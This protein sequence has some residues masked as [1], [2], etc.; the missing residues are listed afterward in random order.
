MFI[1]PKKQRVQIV[2]LRFSVNTFFFSVFLVPLLNI[3]SKKTLH[4]QHTFFLISQ[5]TTLH[6][7]DTFFLISKKTTLHVQ[8]TFFLTSK[9][10]LCTCSTLFCTFPCRCF[11][12]P[13]RQTSFTFL[14]TRF[15]E[16]MFVFLFTLFF[17]RRSFFT[18]VAA[19]ISHFL[20]AAI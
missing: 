1:D 10:Q 9:K 2:F 20:T 11:A 18:L 6:V 5:K 3:I 17:H 14:F 7:Q 13:K 12:Q 8:H 16:E 19:S 15:M 4:V